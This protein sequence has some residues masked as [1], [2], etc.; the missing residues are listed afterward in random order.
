MSYKSKFV[1]TNFCYVDNL[2]ILAYLGKNTVLSCVIIFL[3]FRFRKF[4]NLMVKF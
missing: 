1:I 4:K 2:K 3:Y